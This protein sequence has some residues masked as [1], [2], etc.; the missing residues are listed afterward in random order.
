MN[1][2]KINYPYEDKNEEVL[3]YTISNGILMTG[4]LPYRHKDT[5]MLSDYSLIA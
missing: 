4:G 3:N 2:A 1:G 5:K